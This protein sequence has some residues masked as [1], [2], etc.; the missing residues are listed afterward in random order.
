M[1]QSS[2]FYHGGFGG[3]FP[4]STKDV[5]LGYDR[6]SF[7]AV[8]YFVL[9]EASFIALWILWF[10]LLFYLF[11]DLRRIAFARFLYGGLLVP[12]EEDFCCCVRDLVIITP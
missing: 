8:T 5:C 10:F 11:P 12:S 6:T 9:D 3:S 1:S 4:L 7:P 2:L